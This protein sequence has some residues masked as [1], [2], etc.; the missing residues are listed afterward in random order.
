[1]P[2]ASKGLAAATLSY[3]L[4]GHHYV[5]PAAA[6]PYLG[7]GLDWSLF[8]VSALAAHETAG[9]LPVRISYGA[10]LH[11]LPGVTVTGRGGGVATGYLTT[12]SARVFGAALVRQFQGDHRT[13]R[14]GRDGMFAGGE[15]VALAG[16]PAAAARP[17]LPMRV[18][19]V[20]ATNL[21][22][23]PDT[24]DVVFLVNQDN[25]ALFGDPFES[26]NDF[27]HGSTKFS[28]PAGN[29]LALGMFFGLSGATRL[30]VLPHV[31]VSSAASTTTVPI[32]ESAASSQVSFATP[33]PGGH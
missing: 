8:D 4:S 33:Q 11:A 19:K 3:R 15:S 5:I 24:G 26:M 21:A 25:S 9:R 28:V 32:A 17:D 31:T 7:R 27:Y 22:G 14:Y 23:H 6:I 10:R 29:Y 16:A 2:A 13:G 1:M 18:L 20:K 12:R 30:V